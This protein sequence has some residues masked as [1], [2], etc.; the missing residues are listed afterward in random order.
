MNHRASL[1]SL[2]GLC[3]LIAACVGTT[4]DPTEPILK[5]IVS[6]QDSDVRETNNVSYT[7]IVRPAGISIYM[8]G[9]HRLSLS[10]GRFLLLESDDVDLNGYVGEK[11]MLLG[12][13]RPTVESE[14]LIMRVE[15]I[16]LI[17]NTEIDED[18]VLPIDVN[19]NEQITVSEKAVV[20]SEESAP[21]ATEPT[22]LSAVIME[23]DDVPP[24]EE[25]IVERSEDLTAIIALMSK[26]DITQ[27]NWTQSY[28]TAHIGFCLPIHRNWWFKS[29]GTT[30]ES[31][32]HIEVSNEPI[33]DIGEGP[34]VITLVNG[35]LQSVNATDGEVKTSANTATGFR[36]WTFGRHFVI[37]GDASLLDAVSYMTKNLRTT[38]E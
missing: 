6:V 22:E 14:G 26:Q 27:S 21:P 16:S 24:V 15:S 33:E 37:T 30:S 19:T 28:C 5:D 2:L 7:G 31:F 23:V 8:E 34:I 12:A 36:D 18:Q 13:V 3:V 1:T 32:W 38:E 4:E 25:M 35:T 20:E 29:F 17:K 9:T 10:D 11:A